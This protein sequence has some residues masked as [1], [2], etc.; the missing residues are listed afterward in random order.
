MAVVLFHFIYHYNSFQGHSF[1]VPEIARVGRLGVQLFFIISGFVIFWSISRS[2]KPI[3][4]VWSRFCRLYPV[5]WVAL[6]ITFTVV[7]IFSLPGREVRFEVFVANFLMFHEYL[8]YR[9]VDGVYWT[10]TIELA[11]YFW[12]LV[13][14]ATGQ[15]KHIEKILIVWVLV[16][17]IVTLDSLNI[18][19][20]YKLP[21]LLLLDYI[22]LFAAGICFFRYKDKTHTLWTHLLIVLCVLALAASY[23]AA[24]AIVIASFF[25]I[26]LLIINNKLRILRNSIFVYFGSIS[27]TLYLIHQNIGYIIINKTYENNIHPFVGIAAA[28]TVAIILAHILMVY[29]ERPSLKHLKHRFKS[30]P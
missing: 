4:F 20:G 25:A 12:M 22:E 30:S 8:G 18:D 7:S 15:M 14:F 24:Q 5:F 6:I 26:F 19:L 3:D 28:I 21:R 23:H 29:V 1:D 13:I 9:H 16:A 27:Y 10:L 17:T 2:K 11:F